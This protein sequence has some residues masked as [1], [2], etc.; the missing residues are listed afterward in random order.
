MNPIDALFDDLQQT[1]ASLLSAPMGEMDALGRLLKR[2]AAL[3]ERVVETIDTLRAATPEQHLALQRSHQAGSQ[4]L[5]QLILAKHMLSSELSQLKREQCF[6][7]TMAGQA[8]AAHSRVNL[9][10]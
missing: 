5:R 9:Q 10:G 6:F 3:I 2:R 7:E 4:T 8:P 1:D